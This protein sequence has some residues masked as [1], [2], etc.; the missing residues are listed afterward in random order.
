MSKFIDSLVDMQ[1]NAKSMHWEKTMTSIRLA[2]ELEEK[3]NA[4]SEMERTTKSEIVKRALKIYID[5][6]EEGL[7][8]CELGR[9]LFGNH[10]SGE[11]DLSKTYKKR[12]K[13]KLRE[14]RSR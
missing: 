3:L 6:Y 12:L 1:H 2:P 11:K 9:D 10:G 8:P 7:T 5:R 4:I 14:K 13:D